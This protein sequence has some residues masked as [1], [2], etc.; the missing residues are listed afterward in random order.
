MRGKRLLPNLQCYE[1]LL[2]ALC[3]VGNYDAAI[4]VIKDFKDSGRQVSSFICNVFLLHTLKSQKLLKT[5]YQSDVMGDGNSIVDNQGNNSSVVM[6]LGYLIYELSGI[7]R[8]KENL[9]NFDEVIEQ[10]FPMDIYTYNLLLRASFK[11]GRMDCAYHLFCRMLYKGHEP[12]RWT[13][14]T[15]VHGFCKLGYNKFA[16]KWMEEMSRSGD[17]HACCCHWMWF[18]VS[19]APSPK[20]NSNS[21]SPVTTMFDDDDMLIK[22]A[23]VTKMA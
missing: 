20:S 11:A 6:M 16:D 2:R 9:E 18:S 23:Y 3:S 10:H 22:E 17:L 14:D 1:E 12:N 21:S 15:M 4:E 7:M 5:W 13:Y 19:Q 8:M